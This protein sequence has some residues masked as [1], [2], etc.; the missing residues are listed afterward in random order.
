MTHETPQPG[1]GRLPFTRDA[2]A[3]FLLGAMGGIIAFGISYLLVCF[4]VS[5]L[6][7]RRQRHREERELVELVEMMELS[8]FE[9]DALP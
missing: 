6:R 4:I 9:P 8:D 3:G 5:N 1:K 2:A 7:A